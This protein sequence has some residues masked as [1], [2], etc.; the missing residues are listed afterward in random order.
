MMLYHL[1]KARAKQCL[2]TLHKEDQGMAF[3][4]NRK[5]RLVSQDEMKVRIARDHAQCVTIQQEDW[6]MKRPGMN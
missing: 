1:V 3:L 2:T 4:E 6:M 5:E